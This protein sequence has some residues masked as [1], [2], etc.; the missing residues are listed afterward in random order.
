MFLIYTDGD[1]QDD[2]LPWG[3]TDGKLTTGVQQQPIKVIKLDL[4]KS[5]E[6]SITKALVCVVY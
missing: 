4:L 5:I 6:Y 1:V 2:G 3:S